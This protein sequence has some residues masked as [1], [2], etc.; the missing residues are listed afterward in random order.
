MNLLDKLF[1]CRFHYF[2]PELVALCAQMDVVGNKEL[3]VFVSQTDLKVNSQIQ[4]MNSVIVSKACLK[5]VD[6]VDNSVEVFRLT[7]QY[8][9]QQYLLEVKSNKMKVKHPETADITF[10]SGIF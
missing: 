2:V 3:C 6:I 5:L 10:A 8:T 9:K 7:R 4:I 1:E